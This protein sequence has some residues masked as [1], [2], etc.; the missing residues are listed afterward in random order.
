MS[1]NKEITCSFCGRPKS[2]VNLMIGGIT[3]HICDNCVAQAGN[4][5]ED[6]ID[7][8]KITPEAAELNLLNPSEL[9]EHLDRYVIGQDDAKKVL[10]V[11]VYNHYK[12]VTQAMADDDD[13]EV[14]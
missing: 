9:K 10:S 7:F 2:E 12:R 14:E 6:E 3:G 4:I 11:S 8:S 13:I 5:V 1:D